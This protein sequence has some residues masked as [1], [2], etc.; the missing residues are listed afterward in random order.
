MV[1]FGFGATMRH[2]EKRLGKFKMVSTVVDP[3]A[4]ARERAISDVEQQL[5]LTKLWIKPLS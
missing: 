2:E 4:Q 1:K 3:G 5:K